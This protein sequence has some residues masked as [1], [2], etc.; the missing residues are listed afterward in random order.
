[1]GAENEDVSGGNFDIAPDIEKL[2]ARIDSIEKH[3]NSLKHRWWSLNQS[4]AISA[5]DLVQIADLAEVL[6]QQTGEGQTYLSSISCRIS[7]QIVSLTKMLRGNLGASS[8]LVAGIFHQIELCGQTLDVVNQMKGR[9]VYIEASFS[10]VLGKI[11]E[12]KGKELV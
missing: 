5:F 11:G 1:M 6:C 8:E 7:E 9:L 10:S 4:Q 12:L 3:A 2:K